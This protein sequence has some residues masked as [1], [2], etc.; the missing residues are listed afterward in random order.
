MPTQYR[1]VYLL[2]FLFI[3]QSQKVI[4]FCSTCETVNLLQKMISMFDFNKVNANRNNVEV[5]DKVP[6]ILFE[7][8]VFKL[9]GDLDHSDRKVNFKGFDKAESAVLICTDVASRGLDFKGVEWIVQWDL[10]SEVNIYVNRVGRT[11]RIAS[12]GQSIAFVMPDETDYVKV[13]KE[14][15]NFRMTSKNRFILAKVFEEQ[16]E[17]KNHAEDGFV[18]RHLK[19]VDDKDERNESLHAIRQALGK[20]MLENTSLREM[21]RFAKKSSTRA[22][23]G[24]SAAFRSIF[25][26]KKLNLTEFAR[27]FGL[28]KNVAEQMKIE[29]KKSGYKGKKT[30]ETK[31]ATAAQVESKE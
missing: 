13:M 21:A 27:S 3:N 9:H 6:Q 31:E 30:E 25:D 18:F 1:L 26:L 5:A 24:H 17:Q 29:E 16:L 2:Q 28:Y 23:A 14:K 11:A 8:S 20:Q 19:N 7:G 4:V 12:S 22:Y 15:Y 10:S